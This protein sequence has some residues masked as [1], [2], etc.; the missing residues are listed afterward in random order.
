M[1][2]V[3]IKNMKLKL[4]DN[5]VLNNINL[6]LER[7]NR[8][9][10]VGINGSGKSCLLRTMAGMHIVREG[11]LK[12]DDKTS[13]QDQ[14][15]GL[16][17]LGESWSRSVAFSGHSIAYQAD[18]KVKEMMKKVQEEN[19][20]RK[21]ILTKVLGINPEWRMH[22]VSSGQRR[23]VRL[24]LGLLKP[25]KIALIDEMTMDLDIITRV[26]FM[27]WLKKESIVNNACIIYATHIFDGLD[28]WPTHIA[29]IKPGGILDIDEK[30][31]IIK[32]SEN[33]IYQSIAKKAHF[34]LEQDYAFLERENIVEEEDGEGSTEFKR[35]RNK[36]NGPQRGYGSGRLGSL[37]ITEV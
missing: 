21:E 4:G 20:E 9:I 12:I 26:K 15:N 36:S 17:F 33:S 5:Y 14:C 32:K 24:F 23:R 10:L 22:L 3:N 19:K 34:L 35:S 25:F 18:I 1:P 30:E 2:F 11:I 27:E 13:F 29:H 16:A 6:S 28:D 37:K 31:S 7:G 8:C